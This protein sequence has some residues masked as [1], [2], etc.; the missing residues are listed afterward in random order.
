MEMQ[1]FYQS[2]LGNE[3]DLMNTMNVSPDILAK[4]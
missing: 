4:N 3:V 2:S 1:G